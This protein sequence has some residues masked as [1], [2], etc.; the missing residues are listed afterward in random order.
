MAQVLEQRTRAGKQLEDGNKTGKL[1]ED[2]V[3]TDKERELL[4]NVQQLRA[5]MSLYQVCKWYNSLVSCR[6][7][8]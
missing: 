8:R 7:R 4:E 1:L 6:D 2:G 5:G 3:E